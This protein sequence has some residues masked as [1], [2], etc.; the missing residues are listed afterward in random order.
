MSLSRQSIAL[1]LTTKNKETKHHMHPKDKKR[2]RKTAL[3][4][5]TNYT[6]VCYASS[7]LW[8]RNGADPI[9]TAPEPTQ[10]LQSPKKTIHR[11]QENGYKEQFIVAVHCK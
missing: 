10:G 11:K 6:L 1:A 8:L 2:N 9:F 3:V 7:N 5:K 4:N